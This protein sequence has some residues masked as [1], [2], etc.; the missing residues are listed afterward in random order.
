MDMITMIAIILVIL[1]IAAIAYFGTRAISTVYT[2]IASFVT[3]LLSNPRAALII[4]A[5]T[6]VLCITASCFG[7]IRI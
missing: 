1:A 4:L 2:G 3:L 6:I 7:V 5:A